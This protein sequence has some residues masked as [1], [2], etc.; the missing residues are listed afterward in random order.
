MLLVVV[1]FFSIIFFGKKTRRRI[2]RELLEDKINIGGNVIHSSPE[3]S[4]ASP[5]SLFFCAIAANLPIGHPTTLRLVV[6]FM[7]ETAIRRSGSSFE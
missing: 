1:L 4:R 3:Q 5:C 6:V 2:S 7:V